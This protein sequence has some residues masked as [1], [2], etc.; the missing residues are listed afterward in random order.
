MKKMAVKSLQ[1]DMIDSIGA[2]IAKEIDD[3]IMSS[4]LVE[5]GWTPVYFLFKNNNHAV[6]IEYWLTETCKGK[7][8]RYNSDYLF[9]DK[10]D[11]EWFILR[12][13]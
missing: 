4:L 1:D 8:A 10:Q 7:W 6:D 5:V 11:A 9:E 3:G 13:S 12:W 2:Q